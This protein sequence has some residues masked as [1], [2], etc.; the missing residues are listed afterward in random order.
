VLYFIEYPESVDISTQ[1]LENCSRWCMAMMLKSPKPPKQ[2]KLFQGKVTLTLRPR[3]RWLLRDPILYDMSRDDREMGFILLR[4]EFILFRPNLHKTVLKIGVF[5]YILPKIQIIGSTSKKIIVFK[6]RI[7]FW[8]EFWPNS[9]KNV[10][11]NHQNQ[12]DPFI[13]N[14]FYKCNENATNQQ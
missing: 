3:P 4:T 2:T 14:N 5:A 11:P 8:V 6:L 13:I 10:A 9:K 1:K 12:A 7:A